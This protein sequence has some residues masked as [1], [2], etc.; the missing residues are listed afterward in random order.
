[1][2]RQANEPEPLIINKYKEATIPLL[3]KSFP[4]LNWMELEEGVDYSVK[5]RLKD[6]DCVIDNNYLMQQ[7]QKL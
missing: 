5:N 6:W 7:K 2:I 3:E 1:M 4:N